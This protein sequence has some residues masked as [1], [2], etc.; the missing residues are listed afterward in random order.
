MQ[1]THWAWPEATNNGP[2]KRRSGAIL[3][4]EAHIMQAAEVNH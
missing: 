4:P 3:E 1:D 2:P